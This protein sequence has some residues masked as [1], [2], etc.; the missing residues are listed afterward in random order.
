MHGTLLSADPAGGMDILYPWLEVCMTPPEP[1]TETRV[2]RWGN[3]VVMLPSSTG[4]YITQARVI[5]FGRLIR[6]ISDREGRLETAGT[7]VEVTDADLYLAELF[8]DPT[9][10]YWLNRRARLMLQTEFGR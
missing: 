6:A 7:Q 10:Q 9:W 1:S 2:E 3:Q 5:D 4:T 8:N